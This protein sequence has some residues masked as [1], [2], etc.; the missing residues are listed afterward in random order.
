MA[1]SYNY[2]N[3]VVGNPRYNQPYAIVP[4]PGG[5]L[6]VYQ[7]GYAP[8]V[9]GPYGSQ[10]GSHDVAISSGWKPPQQTVVAGAAAAAVA[11]APTP[12]PANVVVD[13]P[14]P[15]PAPAAAPTSQVRNPDAQAAAAAGIPYDTYEAMKNTVKPINTNAALGIPNGSGSAATSNESQALAIEKSQAEDAAAM[16]AANQSRALAIEKS[17]TEDAAAMASTQGSGSNLPFGVS[18]HQS[19]TGT[20]SQV[21][22]PGDNSSASLP[23][24]LQNQQY[25]GLQPISGPSSSSTNQ[26]STLAIASGDTYWDLENKNGWAHGT[27]QA[28]NPNFEAHHL[29]PGMMINTPGS[30]T[31]SNQGAGLGIAVVG[32]EPKSGA[33]LGIA[34]PGNEQKP[35]GAGL[36]IA[37]PGDKPKELMTPA[38]Q[39][40][41]QSSDYSQLDSSAKGLA[42]TVK[43][44]L[45]GWMPGSAGTEVKDVA[46]TFIEDAQK[47]NTNTDPLKINHNKNNAG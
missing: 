19:D 23:P 7:D 30:N 33:G 24:G 40:G 8:F 16:A 3:T 17:Q 36:G 12:P 42:A 2:I 20:Q 11:A 9:A 46:T 18:L 6:H 31:G 13:K 4:K 41:P 32:T 39:V 1:Y 47:T 28:L 37:V 44:K 22:P 27:L 34:V 43:A 38:A 26:S 21:T 10:P 15:A 29:H 35:D 25:A 45:A 5:A 14:T